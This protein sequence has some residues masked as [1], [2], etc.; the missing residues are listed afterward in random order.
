MFMILKKG[1]VNIKSSEM[2]ERMVQGNSGEVAYEKDEK[3]LI[4]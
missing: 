2:Y 3:C 4:F 1:K